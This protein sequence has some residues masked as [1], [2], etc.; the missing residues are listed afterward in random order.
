MAARIAV[1]MGNIKERKT[2]NLTQLR[3]NSRKRVDKTCGRKRPRAAD[4]DVVGAGDA[5]DDD[6][7]TLATSVLH[8][9]RA[10][11]ADTAPAATLA[12]TVDGM[13]A[14]VSTFTVCNTCKSKDDPPPGKRGA[15]K[16]F[17]WVGCDK[18]LRWFHNVCLGITVT[19]GQGHFE[20]EHCSH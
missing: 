5:N 14:T 4:V 9:K 17:Q 15:R 8:N 3:K 20:C 16:M 1:G 2:L 11:T 6:V 19:K 10:R 13:N 18:C 7:R 12:T